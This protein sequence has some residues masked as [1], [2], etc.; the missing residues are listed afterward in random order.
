M[1]RRLYV[2][3]LVGAALLL[4]A[5]TASPQANLVTNG[6]FEGGFAVTFNPNP[7]DAPVPNDAIPNG[8]TGVQTFSGGV[9]ETSALMMAGPMSGPSAPGVWVLGTSRQ[10]GQPGQSGDWTAV[11]QPL[12]INVPSYSQLSLSID[13]EVNGHN[14]EAGGWA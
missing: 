10:E 1:S 3:P 13:V 12:S 7:F 8:W 9:P 6:D 4:A 2:E 14:L 11:E 5:A